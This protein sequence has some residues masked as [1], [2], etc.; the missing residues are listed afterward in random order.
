MNSKD[1]EPLVKAAGDP[2]LGDEEC[3]TDVN[4]AFD[5]TTGYSAED[6][7]AK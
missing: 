3:L 2:I 1:T 6:L 4:Q 5:E 7:L